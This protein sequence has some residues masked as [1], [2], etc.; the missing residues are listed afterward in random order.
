MANKRTLMKDLDVHL[1][2]SLSGLDGIKSKSL[3]EATPVISP[4]LFLIFNAAVQ[5]YLT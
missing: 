3:Q 4:S 5:F 2:L 1:I